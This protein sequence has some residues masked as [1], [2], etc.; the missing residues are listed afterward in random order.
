MIEEYVKQASSTQT[1]T[2]RGTR[3]VGDPQTQDW[4]M[5]SGTLKAMAMNMDDVF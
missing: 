3:A 2:R 5:T 1:A 4:E